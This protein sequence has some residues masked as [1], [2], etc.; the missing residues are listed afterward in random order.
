M[1]LLHLEQEQE[2]IYL[3]LFLFFCYKF[4]NLTIKYILKIKHLLPLTVLFISVNL[5]NY[6]WNLFNNIETF[7]KDYI[8]R[9]LPVQQDGGLSFLNYL[10]ILKIRYC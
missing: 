9:H 5:I 2:S 8:S 3:S 6:I 7:K 10:Q 4:K 1:L